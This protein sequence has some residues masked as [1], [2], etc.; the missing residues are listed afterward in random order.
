MCIFVYVYY[1]LIVIDVILLD[2]LAVSYYSPNMKE[3][4][5]NIPQLLNSL[6]QRI[7]I[8]PD[9]ESAFTFVARK[10]NMDN[11]FKT[12]SGVTSYTKPLICTYSFL[13]IFDFCTYYNF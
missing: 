2:L 8:T 6:R 9:I 1:L 11:L 10:D 7:P 5:I 3:Y 13:Y 4:S 12:L